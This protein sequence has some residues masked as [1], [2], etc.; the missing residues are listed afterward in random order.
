[1]SMKV[2][3]HID[4][5]LSNNALENLR[6]VVTKEHSMRAKAAKKKVKKVK[7]EVK[8]VVVSDALYLVNVEIPMTDFKTGKTTYQY[9]EYFPGRR[10]TMDEAMARSIAESLKRAGAGGQ[11]VELD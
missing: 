2:I 5:N 6:V 4:G 7:S 3:H 9:A 8:R 1:M 11:L 10:G